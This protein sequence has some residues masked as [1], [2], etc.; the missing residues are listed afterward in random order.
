MHS[1][2]LG[3]ERAKKY[4]TV[5]CQLTTKEDQEYTCQKEVTTSHSTSLKGI[6]SFI[7]RRWAIPQITTKYTKQRSAAGAWRVNI[8][9]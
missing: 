1:M 2:C 5:H 6:S 4:I 7:T 8:V 9:C 3:I